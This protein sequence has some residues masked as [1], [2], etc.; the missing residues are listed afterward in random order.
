MIFKKNEKQIE[1]MKKAGE[2]SAR[3]LREISYIIKPGVSTLEIDELAES[4][5]RLAGGVPAFK[6]LYGFPGTICASINNEIVHGIPSKKVILKEGDILSVDTGAIVDG[7]YGDNAWT[8]PVGK[9]SSDK[10]RLLEATEKSM[11]A[12]LDAARVGNTLGDIG[13]AVQVVAESYGLGI[14]REYTGHGI[15]RSLH[16]DP[17]VPNYGQAHTG[18]KLQEGMVL[19]IEPMLNMGTHKTIQGDDG[20]LVMTADGKDSAHFE[21]TVAITKDG[22]LVLTTEEQHKRPV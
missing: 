21:K 20:W 5:I 1:A 15:G 10:K 7:W 17:N 12:G 4:I 16:E 19:A 11:W 14:V 8:Y 13:H 9:I 2:L 22:P 3:V 6:G 18:I